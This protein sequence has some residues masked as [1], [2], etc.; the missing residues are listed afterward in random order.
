M[1]NNYYLLTF[2]FLIEE[3]V[4]LGTI[5]PTTLYLTTLLIKYSITIIVMCRKQ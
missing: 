1:G 2:Y 3:S 5:V 4:N